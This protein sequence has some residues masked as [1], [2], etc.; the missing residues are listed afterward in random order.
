MEA[1]SSHCEC[2]GGRGGPARLIWAHGASEASG[3]Q[4]VEYMYKTCIPRPR[5][6]GGG[7]PCFAKGFG[8]GDRIGPR[9]R[10]PDYRRLQPNAAVCAPQ[11]GSG[12]G[13]RHVNMPR[14]VTSFWGDWVHIDSILYICGC[15]RHLISPK[16][17]RSSTAA[18]NT[19]NSGSF[20]KF[21]LTSRSFSTM[22]DMILAV[23]ARCI[24]SCRYACYRGSVSR[25]CPHGAP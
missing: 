7:R 1:A 13:H 20:R 12:L 15:H 21:F 8:F 6:R 4:V 14:T 17:L 16:L 9:V 22:L 2:R 19:F 3:I 11:C 25:A 18:L 5:T 24:L 23:P 10:A